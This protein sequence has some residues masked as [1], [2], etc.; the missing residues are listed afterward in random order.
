[1]ARP[2]YADVDLA[3]IRHNFLALRALVGPGVR[4]LGVVKADAYGH[5]AVAVGLALQAAGIDLLG[6]AL[7]EEGI[8]LRVAGVSVPVL[9]MGIPPADEIAAAIEYDLRLTVEDPATAQEIER[10]AA[11][12][13]RAVRVHVKVDTGMGRLGLR[14][15]EAPSAIEAVAR[16]PHLVAEGL[17]THLACADL[18]EDGVTADQLARFRAVL[19]GCAAKGLRPPLA[20][21]ANSSALIRY[22]ESRFDAVRAGLALYGV[23]PC[24]AAGGVDLRPALSLHTHVARLKR[25]RRGEGVSYGHTWRASRDSVLAILPI[26]YADGYPRALSNRGQVRAAGHL[27][28]VVG[29]VCMDMT[30]VDV[31]GAAGAAVG[32]PVVLIEA[33]HESPLSAEALARL[34][35]TIPYEILTGLSRRIPRVCRA[36]DAD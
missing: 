28:P 20:H 24:A 11:A 23:R 10:Q 35:G 36:A 26:G 16:L 9:V 15:E 32:T 7:V 4:L 2:T 17:Y 22:P 31:T 33:A 25:I 6:V 3:A 19:E 1:M 29:A 14:A 30:L 5:G 34:A 12:R 18:P 21:A 8:E 27:A 13:D